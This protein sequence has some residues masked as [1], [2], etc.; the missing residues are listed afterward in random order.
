[1]DNQLDQV[2]FWLG[3]TYSKLLDATKQ[4]NQVHAYAVQLE[5]E[6]KRLTEENAKLI[7]ERAAQQELNKEPPPDVAAG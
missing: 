7:A 4:H 3:A 1:M 2:T 5:G 6:V